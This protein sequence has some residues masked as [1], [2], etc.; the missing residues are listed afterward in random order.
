VSPLPP[1]LRPAS[2]REVAERLAAARRGTPVLILRDGD[3]CQR[4]VELGGG[5]RELSIGRE[6]SSDLALEWDTEVSRLHAVLQRVGEAWVLIDDGLSRNG[7]F[8]NG[9]RLDGR[10][11]LCDGDIIRAG[12]T[13]ILYAAA[14]GSQAR[15]TELTRGLAPPPMTAAQRRVLEAL[16]RPRGDEPFA[17]PSSNREIAEQLFISVDTVKSHLHDLFQL[18]DVGDMPQNRKR[19]ELVRRAFERGAVPG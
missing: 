3:G 15:A 8:V 9:R 16:C 14:A 19:S 10:R 7:S 12:R 5:D 17:G 1:G 4:L 6:P 2:A 18:F 11:R 13:L